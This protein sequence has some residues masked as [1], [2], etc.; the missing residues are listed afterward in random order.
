MKLV[1]FL[2]PETQLKLIRLWPHAHKK[3]HFKGE[4]RRVGYYS[5]K[6]GL[7]CIWLVDNNGNYNWTADIE[8]IKKHFIVFK[9][10][11]NRSIY[12]FKKK[13]LKEI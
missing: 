6:D 9:K 5:K 13:P 4:I 7:D 10:A 2:Y 3:N 1:D 11:R 8:F 12:G